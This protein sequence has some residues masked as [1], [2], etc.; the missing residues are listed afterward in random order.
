MQPIIDIHTHV[1]APRFASASVSVIGRYYRLPMH[2]KG[3]VEDLLQRGS[4]AGVTHYV[5]LSSATAPEEVIPCNNFLYQQMKA[6]PQLIGFGA[7]HPKFE[8]FREE[9]D[10][11]ISLG[12]KGIKFHPNFQVFAIDDPHMMPLY[13]ALEG[14]LPILMHMGDARNDLSAPHR[15]LPVLERF[16]NLTIIAGH[17]G[18]YQMWPEAE[19]L[20]IGRNIYMDCSST[21][22]FLPPTKAAQLIRRHG[23]DK[24]LFGSDYP[25][26]DY[27]DELQRFHALGL[28]P[29][30]EH[31][32]LY[33]NARRLLGL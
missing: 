6:H 13:E 18:G 8:G 2:G 33:N 7:L 24:V 32:I 15:L 4:A 14:R 11:L 3:T 16:P 25:M 28:S 1:F 12:F 9:I 20:L 17:M 31:C 26:W 27:P 5:M 19:E 10:R 30:E 29:A 22:P 23:V 21:L